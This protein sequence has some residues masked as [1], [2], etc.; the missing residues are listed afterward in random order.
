MVD[1]GAKD[2][3]KFVNEMVRAKA[4]VHGE[5]SFKVAGAIMSF[6]WTPL[7]A[8]ETVGV[9]DLVLPDGGKVEGSSNL[10]VPDGW[11]SVIISAVTSAL[12]EMSGAAPRT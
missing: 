5:C 2:V 6:Y 11:L 9:V 1:L 7:G 12:S 4:G 10:W 8:K 3:V